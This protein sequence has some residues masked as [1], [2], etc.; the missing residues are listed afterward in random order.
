MK[1]MTAFFTL[2]PWTFF[3]NICVY[4]HRY[5]HLSV[6]RDERSWIG[7]PQLD[8]VDHVRH[9]VHD[10]CTMLRRTGHLHTAVRRRLYLPVRGIRTTAG[11]PL[12]VGR[13]A[14]ICVSKSN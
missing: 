2:A 10:R 6:G 9:V 8:H 14:R 7:R 4:A 12:P 5:I 13:H 11:V 1:Y 3:L